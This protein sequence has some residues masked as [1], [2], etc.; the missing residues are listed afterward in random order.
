[1]YILASFVK[2]KVSGTVLQCTYYLLNEVVNIREGTEIRMRPLSLALSVS[3]SLFLQ[4]T[5]IQLKDTEEFVVSS[6]TM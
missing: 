2:D 3:L 5:K 6:D 4:N 1:M